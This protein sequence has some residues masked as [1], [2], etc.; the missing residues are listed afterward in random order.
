LIYFISKAYLSITLFIGL[1]IF[2]FCSNDYNEQ[3]RIE[4]VVTNDLGDAFETIHPRVKQLLTEDFFWSF[5]N[6]SSP[7]G[8]DDGYDAFLSFKE[9]R[10]NN[11]N[12]DPTIFLNDL[13]VNWGYT[14]FDLEVE[15]EDQIKEFISLSQLHE[16]TL[17][18]QNSATIAV[19]FG[20]FI[21]EG[22]ID[23]SIKSLVKEAIK[24]EQ[25]P[26]LLDKWPEEFK[27]DREKELVLMLSKLKLMN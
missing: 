9:W 27:S 6:E 19:G 20:Q 13:I 18:G 25:L 14:A 16:R 10:K 12:T 23:K 15:E 8:N 17:T 1:L 24:R 21:I 3:V 5:T 22:K 26:V 4:N 7:F 2:S 11:K